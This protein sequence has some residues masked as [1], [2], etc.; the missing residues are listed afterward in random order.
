MTMQK[1]LYGTAILLAGLS[2]LAK[3]EANTVN[4]APAQKLMKSFPSLPHHEIDAK[5]QAVQKGFEERSNLFL[6]GKHFQNWTANKNAKEI[7]E[8][9]NRIREWRNHSWYTE[10][11][12]ELIVSHMDFMVAQDLLDKGYYRQPN[13][14]AFQYNRTDGSY[15]SSSL[16]LN[17]QRFLALEGPSEQN[18]N[19]FF[20]LLQ[21]FQVTQLVRL[22]P[23]ASGEEPEI[24]PYWQDRIKK[25]PK[26]QGTQGIQGQIIEIPL[27]GIDKTY[28]I[29]YVYTDAWENNA[30]TDTTVLLNLIQSVRKANTSENSLIACHCNSGVG[31]TGTFIA[32]FALI[33]EIDRQIAAGTA[34]DNLDISIEKI[35]MQLSLQKLHMVAKPDQYLMLYR[36]V[37]QHIQALKKQKK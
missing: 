10:G 34:I 12:G 13:A 7:F 33:Q 16:I 11:P 31:R 27:A 20:K 22:A 36:L 6:K 4:T 30:K 19:Q 35:V 5:F 24:Y 8:E 23:F 21:N 17:G 37:D 25:D 28:S 15:N 29:P 2:T 9:F 1:L 26:A 3:V 32:G 14:I 18:V